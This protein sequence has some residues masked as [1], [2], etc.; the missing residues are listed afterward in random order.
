[1]P[2]AWKDTLPLTTFGGGIGMD[3][4]GCATPIAKVT[5]HNK[6]SSIISAIALS[7][8]DSAADP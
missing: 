2:G 3:G 5:A 8:D 1:M 4:V 6:D 7:F